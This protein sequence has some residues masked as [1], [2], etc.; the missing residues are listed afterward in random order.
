MSNETHSV[1]KAYI[2]INYKCNHVCM[3]LKCNLIRNEIPNSCNKT[4]YYDTWLTFRDNS[5][6][7]FHYRMQYIYTDIIQLTRVVLFWQ[8]TRRCKY[9]TVD[10]LDIL[11]ICDGFSWP[12]PLLKPSLFY[13]S[14]TPISASL[15]STPASRNMAPENTKRTDLKTLGFGLQSKYLWITAGSVRESNSKWLLSVI[16]N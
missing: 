16:K 15:S 3:Y 12:C 10:Q 1:P 7:Q 6:F 13:P 2:L 9:L 14:G 8:V 5:V 4:F 11:S